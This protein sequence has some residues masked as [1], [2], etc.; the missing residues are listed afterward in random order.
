MGRYGV[1]QPLVELGTVAAVAE[2]YDEGRNSGCGRPLEPTD[3]GPVSSHSDD[4]GAEARI[5]C[6]IEQRLEV[7]SLSRD[8]HYQPRGQ[9]TSRT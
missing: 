1:G 8:E 7:R 4:L 9:R 2:A 3:P 6:G 5:A